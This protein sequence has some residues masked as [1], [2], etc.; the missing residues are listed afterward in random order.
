MMVY[1]YGQKG[2]HHRGGVCQD[3]VLLGHAVMGEGE[4]SLALP[5][6]FLV[7]I[8]D[9]VG[10]MR[11]GD[12]A[13]GLA[14]SD[15]ARRNCGGKTAAE[16]C[17]DLLALNEKIREI[18]RQAESCSGMASTFVGLH[19]HGGEASVIWAGNSRLYQVTGEDVELL[20]ADHNQRNDWLESGRW[21]AGN[22]EALTVYLGM[23]CA[24]LKE[25]LEMEKI[26]LPGTERFFLTS[27]GVH[28]HIP[29]ASLRALF[30]SGKPGEEL[31]P[32]I[33][34]EAVK[35]GST[36]DISIVMAEWG[37]RSSVCGGK[38]RETRPSACGRE[39]REMRRSVCGGEERE[40]L[41]S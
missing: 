2:I 37:K 35:N 29:E 3:T 39:E 18:G 27:D 19:V 5:E 9:G 31:L 16:V 41:E 14:M 21:G 28:D 26:Y 20:T 33:A 30:L 36:D 1:G 25:R 10:G 7:G 40:T 23:P 22:G 15:L 8:A 17:A 34:G 6:N 4:L 24:R 12:A 32:E 38:K 11:A 13:S